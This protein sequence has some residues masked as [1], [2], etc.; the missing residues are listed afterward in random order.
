[1]KQ[2]LRTVIYG[3]DVQ[4]DSRR[5]PPP[6]PGF[7]LKLEHVRFVVDIS[8]QGLVF[9]QYLDFHFHSFH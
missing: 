3:C 5:L 6:R 8:A 2:V 4:A 7:E 1:M 9:S